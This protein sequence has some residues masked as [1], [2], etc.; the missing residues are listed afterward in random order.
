ME[1]RLDEGWRLS[2][3]VALRPEPFGALTYHFRNR[4]LIFLKQPKLADLA[5]L[6]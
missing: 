6:S 1:L 5:P 3:A 4:K 2:P